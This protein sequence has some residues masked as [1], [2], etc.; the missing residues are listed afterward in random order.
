MRKLLRDKIRLWALEPGG[1]RGHPIEVPSASV[2]ELRACDLP[3]LAC[4]GDVR[5]VSHDALRVDG[6]PLRRVTTRCR[7]CSWER[8]VWVQISPTL[9]N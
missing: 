2:V 3:C 1:S 6:R 8:E 5:V 7:R 4:D 9:M